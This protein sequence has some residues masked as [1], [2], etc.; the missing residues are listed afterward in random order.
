MSLNTLQDIQHW[1]TSHVSNEQTE[2]IREIEQDMWAR[3]IGEYIQCKDCDHI[4]GKQEVFSTLCDEIKN[5]TVKKIIEVLEISNIECRK[6]WWETQEIYGKEY[7][8]YI[9]QRYKSYNSYLTTYQS[10]WEIQGFADWYT[11][12]FDEIYSEEFEAYY[13]KIWKETIRKKIEDIL[14]LEN[15]QGEYITISSIWLTQNYS[16]LITFF[17]LLSQLFQ[18]IPDSL[19]NIPGIIEVDDS[20]CLSFI[21]QKLWA[22]KLDLST[23]WEV[24]NKNPQHHSSLYIIDSPIKILKQKNTQSIRKILKSF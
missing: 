16:N 4:D 20:N 15:Y 2:R 1:Q 9:K 13:H 24:E 3:W 11:A 6:C 21:Y 8:E 14:W 10:D 23:L 19:N 17:K 18:S 5:L 7:L 22:K 12:T